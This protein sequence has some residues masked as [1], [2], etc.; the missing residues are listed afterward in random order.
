MLHMQLFAHDAIPH[1]R[2][3]G[4]TTL[5]FTCLPKSQQLLQRQVTVYVDVCA[6]LHY[7]QL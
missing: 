6:G 5:C 2:I 3:Q 7:V 1:D 4:Y